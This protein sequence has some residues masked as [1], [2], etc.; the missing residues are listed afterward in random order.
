MGTRKPEPLSASELAG[1]RMSQADYRA[2][3]R[4]V[5]GTIAGQESWKLERGQHFRE[6]GAEDW[7]AFARGDWERSL[8]LIEEDRHSTTHLVAKATRL[9]I[10]QYRA[11]VVEQPIRPY[12]QWE[13]HA[14]MVRAECG[15]RIRV[16]PVDL[17]RDLEAEGELPELIT[18]GASVAYQIL[19]TES[20]ELAGGVKITD[21]R[22]VAHITDLTRHLYEA[23]EDLA[24]FFEREVAHLP[25][26]RGE[27]ALGG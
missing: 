8:E 4:A 22:V 24:T 3:F 17:V 10:G 16:V 25:P 15:E 2:D 23:G 12:L 11:R 18:L 5:L 14:L 21:T 7:E 13:L 19:Y 1:E 27:K 20:G 6:P 26:P 9:G